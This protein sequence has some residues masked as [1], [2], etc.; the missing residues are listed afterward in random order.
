[1]E[2]LINKLLR[3]WTQTIWLARFGAAFSC[4]MFAWEY[5][6]GEFW[7]SGFQLICLGVN[8]STIVFCMK[9]RRLLALL[10]RG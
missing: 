4:T 9:H 2:T 5:V 7:W 1:M 8:I 3:R 10:G 6:R